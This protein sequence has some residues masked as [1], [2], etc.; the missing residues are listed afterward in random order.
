VTLP[1]VLNLLSDRQEGHTAPV[2]NLLSD[3]QEGHTAPV[4]NLLSQVQC[5]PPGYLT[6]N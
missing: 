1:P 4:L 6:I 3:I 5:D 2:L